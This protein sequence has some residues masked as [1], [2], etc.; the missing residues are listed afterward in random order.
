MIVSV[1][2][3]T[4]LDQTLYI[5]YFEH[6]A[7]I[8]STR[9]QW[10]MGGKPADASWI[11]GTNG[12][13]S[14]ALGF[15]GGMNGK[16]VEAMLRERGVTPDF[17]WAD[18]ETRVCTVIVCEDPNNR[19]ETTVTTV[20]M[21]IK[22]EHVAALRE[23]YL[24]VLDGEV[25]AVVLGGTLPRGIEPSF[26][27]DLIGLA[28]QRGIPVIFDATEPNLSAGLQSGP[29]YIKPNRVELEALVNRKL[30]T[31][32]DVYT[33]GREVVDRYGTVPVITMGGDGTMC[34]LPDKAYY[35]PP[36]DIKVVNASG[37]GDG[38]LAGITQMAAQGLPIEEGLRIGTAY[39]SAVCLTYGTA[40][41]RPEDVQRLKPQV[42]LV[43]YP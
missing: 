36:L 2:A 20:M 32:D 22:P 41:C 18:G 37:A 5:P 38:M 12:V 10:S 21:E 7:T 34:V 11:L 30:P 4:T 8:R 23:Q 39:A 17:I 3:N 29:N 33:A 43:P 28:R 14:L 42:E 6:N 9:V 16:K 26:Y 15:A 25:E 40:D 13:P 35:I 1:T 24:R 19:F 27:T 31:L